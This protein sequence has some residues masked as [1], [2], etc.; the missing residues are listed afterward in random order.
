MEDVLGAVTDA[1]FVVAD[2]VGPGVDVCGA[3]VLWR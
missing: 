2:V 1:L 3:V